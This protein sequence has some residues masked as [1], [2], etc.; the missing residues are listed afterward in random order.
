[1][2]RFLYD[3]PQ[4][5]TYFC[6]EQFVEWLSFFHKINYINFTYLFYMDQLAERSWFT[7][8]TFVGIPI[9]MNLL[10]EQ[11][12]FSIATFINVLILYRLTCG[13][14]MFLYN[15]KQLR[16]NCFW[17]S[18]GAAIIF[19]DFHLRTDF[20]PTY[21]RSCHVSLSRLHWRTYFISTY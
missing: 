19:K 12:C 9:Y 7:I 8:T 16:V 21:S 14:A 10:S 11:T 3:D 5:R 15:V 2:A 6:F 18:C 20:V 17:P 4:L 1:M 13:A